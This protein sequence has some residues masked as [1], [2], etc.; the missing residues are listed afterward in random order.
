M[1]T[2]L[3]SYLDNK[4][5]FT[6]TSILYGAIVS[7]TPALRRARTRSREMLPRWRPPEPSL[8]SRRVVEFTEPSSTTAS[9][10]L[11]RA[12][13]VRSLQVCEWAHSHSNTRTKQQRNMCASVPNGIIVSDCSLQIL[14]SI[15]SCFVSCGTWD[16]WRQCK[17]ECKN[18]NSLQSPAPDFCPPIG[19]KR[20]QTLDAR[21]NIRKSQAVFSTQFCTSLAS[22]KPL[23]PCAVFMSCRAALTFCTVLA[24]S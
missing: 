2:D 21:S 22:V 11:C 23:N 5:G 1:G 12:P 24:R 8:A 20:K 15:L 9:Q 13:G 17:S 18:A 19:L 6:R 10:Y 3:S 7:G 16:R 14:T 4:R